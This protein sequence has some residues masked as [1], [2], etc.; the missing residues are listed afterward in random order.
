MKIAGAPISWGV[1][2]VPGWGY[3][4]SPD[5]VLD[6]MHALGLRATEFGPQ[7]WLPVAPLLGWCVFVAAGL[8][9]FYAAIRSGWSRRFVDG[10]L[11]EWQIA[12]GVLTVIWGYAMCGPLRKRVAGTGKSVS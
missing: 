11:T 10:A 7:G 1:C 9:S 4:M 8:G 3:Q 12:F 6:E 5:R 2:E